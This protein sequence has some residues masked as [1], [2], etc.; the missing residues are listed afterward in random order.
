MRVR[1]GVVVV[2]LIMVLLLGG[3]LWMRGRLAAF[4]AKLR[5]WR[6]ARLI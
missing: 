1:P 4:E 5:P 3:L 6:F 2:G